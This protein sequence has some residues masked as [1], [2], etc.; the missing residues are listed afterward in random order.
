MDPA[1]WDDVLGG[2]ALGKFVNSVRS[3]SGE[4]LEQSTEFILADKAVLP[5]LL[6][7]HKVILFLAS[8]AEYLEEYPPMFSEDWDKNLC[9]NELRLLGWTIYA[10]SEPAILYGLYPVSFQL[11][12]VLFDERYVNKFGLIKNRIAANAYANLNNSSEGENSGHWRVIGVYVDQ[13][14]RKR[15][16]S[17]LR[18]M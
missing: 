18:S 12:D 17:L 4:S 7:I 3:A 14:S 1:F 8:S 13:V 10:Y 6:K 9:V 15:L 16:C 11:G 5:E 2:P